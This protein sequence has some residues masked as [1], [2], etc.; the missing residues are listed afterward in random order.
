MFQNDGTLKSYMQGG[1]ISH[2]K[3]CGLYPEG[4][5]GTTEMFSAGQRLDYGLSDHLTSFHKTTVAEPAIV[6]QHPLF[7][8]FIIMEF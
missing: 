4:N 6:L 1:T 8:S 7:L 5:G 3:E 2:V